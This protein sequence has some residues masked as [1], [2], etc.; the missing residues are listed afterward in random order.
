M[1][2]NFNNDYISITI[3][4]SDNLMIK[5][6]G[7]I[8]NPNNYSF[9]ELLAPNPIVKQMRYS[10]SGLP[11]ANPTIAFDNTQNSFKIPENGIIHDVNFTYPNGYYVV[12]GSDKISPSVFVI[13]HPKN[14][15]QP[16]HVRLELPDLL[17]L[18]TLTYRPN[19]A[20]GP[21]YYSVKES[22]VQMQGAEDTARGYATAKLKYDLA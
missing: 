14:N 2:Y 1:S 3:E 5:I 13:L 15:N 9:M 7:K 11:F 16:L 19:H 12:G 6:N 10:G 22:L 8:L 17:P 20:K 4:S 18:H 21:I